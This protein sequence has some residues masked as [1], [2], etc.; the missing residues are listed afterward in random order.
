MAWTN[1]VEFP[2]IKYIQQAAFFSFP[3]HYGQ[4]N[5]EN[6]SSFFCRRIFRYNDIPIRIFLCSFA[7]RKKHSSHSRDNHRT[8]RIGIVDTFE[9]PSR[10]RVFRTT[11]SEKAR[12]K[13]YIFQDKESY[14]YIF[15]GCVF[16]SDIIVRK[17]DILLYS[18]GV[19]LYRDSKG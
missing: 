7:W 14:L 6:I 2:G 12:Q 9:D 17:T 19:L 16:R 13:R 18:D 15:L 4:K 3:M 8:S 10:R 5:T 1:Q 11:E